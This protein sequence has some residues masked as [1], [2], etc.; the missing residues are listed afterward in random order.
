MPQTKISD[1]VPAL[2]SRNVKSSTLEGIGPASSVPAQLGR[3]S[4]LP[5]SQIKNPG[6]EGI[7]SP[8][9]ETPATRTRHVTPV[10]FF[11]TDG[12][13]A[14][15]LYPVASVTMTDT[16]DREV[17]FNYDPTGLP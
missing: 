15:R 5:A 11:S 9:T 8:L 17:V 10:T 6:S 4:D 2:S 16:E 13:I 1:S 7:A 14:F 3:A 12:L